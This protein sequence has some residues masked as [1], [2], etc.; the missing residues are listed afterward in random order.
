M[1]DTKGERADPKPK[2]GRPKGSKNG[3]K[4][5][6]D[7]LPFPEKVRRPTV[8]WDQ[9]AS[10]DAMWSELKQ[11]TDRE[12][13]DKAVRQLW[14]NYAGQRYNET[15]PDHTEQRTRLEG[16][17]KQL[18]AVLD[19]LEKLD[20]QSAARLDIE[21]GRDS[22]GGDLGVGFKRF[23]SDAE[24]DDGSFPWGL[25]E[26]EGRAVDGGN[27]RHLVARLIIDQMQWAERALEG[28]A[29]KGG[30]SRSGI[31]LDNTVRQ[32]SKIYEQ[33]GSKKAGSHDRG[34]SG[35]FVRFCEKF[36]HAVHT[37]NQWAHLE[38]R[39]S[40]GRLPDGAN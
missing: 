20:H 5:K 19:H 32:L 29:P 6:N 16:L 4:P 22:R 26:Y 14:A 1:G 24:P 23:S 36:F 17:I 39:H 18:D 30:S 9:I 15:A 3:P 13:F 7:W 27:R 35:P 37:V 34:K 12:N 28:L 31:L 33:H 8:T 21:A 40:I 25:L 11:P 10:L 2:R 38:L